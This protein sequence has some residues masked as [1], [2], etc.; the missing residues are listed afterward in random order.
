MQHRRER[1]VDLGADPQRLGERVGAGRDDHE[2]LQVD[3]VGACTPPLITFIIGTGSV[4][5]SRAAEVRKSETPASAA[6]RLRGRERDAEDR[7]RA[8]PALVR[9]AVELDQRPVE[10]RLVVGVERRARASA[11]SP[12]DVRDRLRDALAAPRVAAVAQLDRLVRAGRGARGDRRAAEGAR[13][14]QDVD[15]DRR[16]AARV[17]DLAGADVGDAAHSAIASLARS[18]YR[19]CAASASALQS[20]PA[21][22][23][24]RS[25]RLDARAEPLRGAPQLELGSTFELARDVDGGEEHVA[26]LLATAVRLALRHGLDASSS[27]SARAISSSRSASAPA[28]SG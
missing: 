1:V 14:E 10:R 18:K 15:L 8:E 5:A 6:A 2:L 25:A 17:E 26:E 27:S 22:A 11:I 9:R 4:R 19:S 12:F 13:L 23:A 3:R 21:A 20:S 28:A 7:V 16:V 24:S